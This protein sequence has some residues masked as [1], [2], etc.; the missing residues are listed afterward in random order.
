LL[1][2]AAPGPKNGL[3]SGGTRDETEAGSGAPTRSLGVGAG[4]APRPSAFGTNNPAPNESAR[5]IV[6]IQ[7]LAVALSLL[8]G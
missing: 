2:G 4:G 7:S 1:I 5:K 6:A 8:T 3:E